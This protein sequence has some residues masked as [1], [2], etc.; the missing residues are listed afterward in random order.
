MLSI[1]AFLKNIKSLRS[2]FQARKKTE[3]IGKLKIE[4]RFNET[5]KEAVTRIREMQ[6]YW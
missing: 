4:N 6:L 1:D 3:Q 2:T 5:I